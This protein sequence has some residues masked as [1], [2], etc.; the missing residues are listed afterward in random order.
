MDGGGRGG[1][2]SGLV[3]FLRGMRKGESLRSSDEPPNAKRESLR[4]SDERA[5]TD[6]RP[7]VSFHFT[8]FY[9][10]FIIIII[11]MC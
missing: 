6:S 4:S 2:E 8:S 11:M 10:V 5:A 7:V 1:R 3:I 9:E